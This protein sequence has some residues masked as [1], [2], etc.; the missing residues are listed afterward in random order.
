[1]VF[2]LKFVVECCVIWGCNWDENWN[3][4]EIGILVKSKFCFIL[5]LIFLRI[6]E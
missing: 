4:V 3:G 1:M 6:E 5:L 2:I